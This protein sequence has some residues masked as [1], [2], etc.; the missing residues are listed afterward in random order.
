MN[1]KNTDMLNRGTGKVIEIDTT[2]WENT[3]LS[4]LLKN[5]VEIICVSR[6]EKRLDLRL[7]GGA[8]YCSRACEQSGSY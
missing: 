2:E 1:F 4:S 5:G 7:G 3:S 8:T 6:S